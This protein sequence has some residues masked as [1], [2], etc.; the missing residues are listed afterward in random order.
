MRMRLPRNVIALCVPMMGKQ[1]ARAAA[2]AG[3]GGGGVA[4]ELGKCKCICGWRN[5]KWNAVLKCSDPKGKGEESLLA[6]T[7][8]SGK[9]SQTRITG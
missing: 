4:G 5:Q 8:G 3:G 2:A 6:T 9:N 1:F 7:G